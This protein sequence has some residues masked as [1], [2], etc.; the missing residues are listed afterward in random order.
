MDKD[1][2]KFVNIIS[3]FGISF[4]VGQLILLFTLGT[5]SFPAYLGCMGLFELIFW[6]ITYCGVKK[7][8]KH[9]SKSE[10]KRWR[11]VEQSFMMLLEEKEEKDQTIGKTTTNFLRLINQALIEND[12]ELDS[13]SI[14]Y[15]MD[16]LHLINANYYDEDGNQLKN[17]NREQLLE[18]VLIQA[19]GYLK[20]NDIS[21]INHR[22]IT[23]IVHSCFFF[24]ED[25]RR[26]IVKE[27]KKSEVGF[28]GMI[29]HSIVNKNVDILDKESYFEER[30]KEV[31]PTAN[32]DIDSMDSYQAVIE[33]LAT[34]DTY[35]S[36]F[37]NVH[38]IEWDMDALKNIVSVITKKFRKELIREIDGY[39]NLQLTSSFIYN[40]MCYAV[41]N[42]RAQVSYP[43]M[44]AV[45]RDWNFIPFK[46]K[47]EI[48]NTIIEELNLKQEYHPFQKK[49]TEKVYQKGKIISFPNGNQI[50]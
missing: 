30:R 37:G 11:C 40:I 17:F 22:V 34:Y 41:V 16:L 10:L 29:V 26:E 8:V 33:G 13:N 21:A 36:Q 20:A 50:S 23:Q 42:N 12:V 1:D 24:S 38:N 9:Q 15:L 31:S 18:R 25:M 45:F 49:K 43:E 35:L 2:S 6:P 4:G 5:V 39:T 46:L 7:V 48:I 3:S 28:D 32:F 19:V 47:F 44:L 14:H 27:Y